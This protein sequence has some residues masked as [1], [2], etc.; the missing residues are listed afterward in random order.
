[1]EKNEISAKRGSSKVKYTN[2]VMKKASLEAIETYRLMFLEDVFAYVPFGRATFFIR[3]LHEDEDI[4]E[5]IN[6]SR[7]I[8]RT[9]LRKKWYDTFNPT[10]QIA[11]YRLICT[12]EERENLSIT[13]HEVTGENG[14]ALLP[15]SIEDIDLSKLTE[16]EKAIL[17][18]ISRTKKWK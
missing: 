8:T 12:K 3:K 18:K 5:A 1:M 7:I 14:S 2:P 15:A 6:K 13:R 11:L 10:T 9:G 4:K 16:E 17:L